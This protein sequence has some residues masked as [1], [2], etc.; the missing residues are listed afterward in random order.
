MSHLAYAKEQRS[1]DLDTNC[2]LKIEFTEFSLE[3]LAFTIYA[4]NKLDHFGNRN[5]CLLW[6]FRMIAF[7]ASYSVMDEK[8]SLCGENILKSDY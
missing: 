4:Q 1:F 5:M 2:L 6:H 3:L 8:H 7:I